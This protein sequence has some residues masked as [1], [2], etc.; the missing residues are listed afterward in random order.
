MDGARIET[1]DD[2]SRRRILMTPEHDHTISSNGALHGSALRLLTN[3]AEELL[4]A[5]DVSQL[6]EH[7]STEL[8]AQ[9]GIDI[10]CHYSVDGATEKLVLSTGHGLSAEERRKLHRLEFASVLGSTADGDGD[11]DG[12]SGSDLQERLDGRAYFAY[13]LLV[14]NTIAGAMVFASRR[15]DPFTP[16]EINLL[17][18]LS[19][20][21]ALALEYRRLNADLDE[22]SQ[23]LAENEQRYRE[24]TRRLVSHQEQ[25]RAM[26][27]DLILTEQRERRRLAAELHDVLAQLLVASKMKLKLVDRADAPAAGSAPVEQIKGLIDEALK[28]TRSLIADLSPTILYEA[29][30]QPAL[31]WLGEQMRQRG[32]NVIIDQRGETVELGED[33]A[34][35]VFQIVKELLSNV[36][37]H[38]EADSATVTL[39]YARPE[40]LTITV[41]D[42]GRG[43]NAAVEQSH[44]DGSK[45]GLFSVRERVAALAGSFE[46]RSSRSTGTT[47]MVCV[48]LRP[49]PTEVQPPVGTPLMPPKIVEQVGAST[50]GIR[51]LL[52][53]DHK[54]VREGFR[55][56]IE[57]DSQIEVA[58]EAANGEEAVE[59]ARSL[60]PDVILMDINMPRMNGIEATRRIKSEMPDVAIIGLSVHD[61]SG[62]TASMIEAGATCYL[63]KGEQSEDLARAIHQAFAQVA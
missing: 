50:A 25:M 60:R 42:R 9:M 40:Q 1:P 33:Q 6:I 13:P 39:D 49:G 36:E 7:L 47:A 35:M 23:R 21:V 11:A 44:A 37:E 19:H 17:R 28:Y 48:P 63:T 18:T 20:Q 61:D 16:L 4:A 58:G 30:L 38:A 55:S 57:T 34:I 5:I 51:V 26:A 31:Q 12:R 24:R 32:L 43:F 29:G 2:A 54:M 15:R 59:M 41:C 52:V 53:D 3:A 46:L 62:L 10:C 45:L 27:S 14:R 8:S 22:R 56:L